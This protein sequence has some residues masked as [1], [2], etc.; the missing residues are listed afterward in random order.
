MA[1][2][3]AFVDNP[4]RLSE[5]PEGFTVV[6]LTPAVLVAADA[7]PF[8]AEVD[9]LELERLGEE[10][11]D[12]IFS[13]CDVLDELTGQAPA[14]TRWRL[15]ELKA[16][17]DGA[18]LHALAAVRLAARY[19]A[20]EALVLAQTG[21]IA[22]AVLPS[23]LA[24]AGVA[25]EGVHASALPV[26]DVRARRLAGARMGIRRALRRRRPRILC[27]DEG[28]ALPDI[29][30]ELRQRGADV[31]LWLPPPRRAPIGALP[32]LARLAPL[33]RIA[34]L[35]VWS[36]V[37]PRLRAAVQALRQDHAAFQASRAAIRRDRPDALLASTYAAPA[38]KAAAAAARAAGVPTIVCRHG[39]LPLRTLPLA[40]FQDLDVVEWSLCWGR[41]EAHY[42]ARHAP[43][44]V[45]TLV[46][47]SPLIERGV[48][49]ALERPVARNE[50]GLDDGDLGILLVPTGFSGDGWFAGRRAPPDL[51][52]LRHQISVVEQCIGVGDCRV[53]V[54]EHTRD[55]GVLEDW[56]ARGELPVSFVRGRQFS[57]LV[58]GPDA[59]VLDFPS[60]TLVQA[61]RGKARIYVVK[62]P[63]TLWEPG[64]VEH[65]ESW[66][67]TFVDVPELGDRLRADVE[68]GLLGGPVS[69]PPEAYEPLCAGG[70]GAAAE[71]AA[72]AVLHI[73]SEHARTTIASR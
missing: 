5:V 21:S 47:G 68:R 40:P 12:R 15:Q 53:V 18:L 34:G 60:T 48:A 1:G 66:G 22:A 38:A 72:D 2:R 46:V 45:R 17:Y 9:E 58:H 19:A 49:A 41:W 32:D 23:T 7:V 56:A 31:I 54:K 30:D 39:E 20:S 13:A 61:L 73:V 3:L 57:E 69:Y 28:Y 8:D 29:R 64:V 44:V 16:F 67:V 50:L 62:H 43:G 71:R 6:A 33:F 63:V 55:R 36:A 26:V 4:S 59:V 70:D 24:D 52:Y 11:L 25:T 65:L 10:T 51:T 42:V 37:E 27:L 35:D 14:S